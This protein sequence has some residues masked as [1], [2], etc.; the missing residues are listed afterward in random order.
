MKTESQGY[1][2]QMIPSSQGFLMPPEWA[3]HEATWL[4]W[5]HNRETWS[6]KRI[7]SVE[8][9]YFQILEALLPHEKVHVLFQ[10]EKEGEHIGKKLQLRGLS[11]PHFIPHVKATQDIWIRDYGPTFIVNRQGQKAWCK[12]IFNGWGNKYDCLKQDNHVFEDAAALIP[13]P[14][15]QAP[16]VLESGSIDVNGAGACLV[17]EQCL[18]NKNRNPKFSRRD[19]ERQLQDFLGVDQVVWLS[20]GILGDDTDGHIDDIAR[21]VKEN[22]IVAAFEINREDV[23]HDILK[24]N[25]EILKQSRD[26][27]GRA[28]NV[29]A[30]PM[31][32]KITSQKRRLPASYA[33]FYIANEVVLVPA[34]GDPQDERAFQILTDVFQ[35]RKIV[36]V[37]CRELIEGLGAI[38]CI[39]QQEPAP[40]LN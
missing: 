4:A 33:N 3:P 10:N 1:Q 34:F 19:I 38:H 18:L 16:F 12:W 22:T 29:I 39:T 14:C 40:L 36:P 11:L 31:P 37:D 35:D 21:F 28:W 27:R 32:E 5:P 20:E 13:H 25:W 15:Y 9:A 2:S 24:K 26:G 6:G 23:N 8:K 17:T 30:L 7:Q